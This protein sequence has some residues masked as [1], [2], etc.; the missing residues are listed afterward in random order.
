MPSKSHGQKQTEQPLR[1]INIAAPTMAC[2]TVPSTS[3]TVQPNPAYT[4]PFAGPRTLKPHALS[5]PSTRK[6]LLTRLLPH[7]AITPATR[8]PAPA[9]TNSLPFPRKYPSLPSL[10]LPGP[11]KMS[12]SSMRSTCSE[13]SASIKSRNSL[14][15]RDISLPSP[16]PGH[17]DTIFGL[18]APR[19]A[20]APT[21]GDDVESDDSGFGESPLSSAEHPGPEDAQKD[22]DTPEPVDVRAL[23]YFFSFRACPSF[24]CLP[25]LICP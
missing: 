25:S 15:K 14:S 2:P 22:K 4:D 5:P 12:S 23:C 16:G 3:S 24:A 17:D 18:D 21:K 20:P 11:R 9:T 8:P 7:N 10:H 19:R 13:S 6:R 1:D